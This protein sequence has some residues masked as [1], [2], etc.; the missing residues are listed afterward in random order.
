MKKQAN[1]KHCFVCGIENEFGLKLKFYQEEPGYVKAETIVSEHFQGYPGVVHGGI[2]AAILDEVSGRSMIG[3][4]PPRF[5]VTAKLNVRY[6]KPVPI[7][8]KLFLEGKAKEDNGRI[9]IVIGAIYNEEHELL[10]E[11]EAVLADIPKQL[12]DQAGFVSD[13]WKVYADE[14]LAE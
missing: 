13:D 9:A 8:K 10:A 12:I 6:R 7:G 1:S 11:S 2:V 14:E 5:M 3:G 4:E